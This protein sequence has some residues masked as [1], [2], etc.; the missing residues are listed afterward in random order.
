MIYP[1]NFL[2]LVAML[3]MVAGRAF[4]DRA[5]DYYN[6]GVNREDRSDWNGALA[7]YN[8][9]IEL[10]PNYAFAYNNRGVVKRT[11]GDLDGALADENK[12][13]GLDPNIAEA[14][15]NRGFLKRLT[16]DLDG[17][18]ADETKAIELKP[19]F[20]QAWYNR[21]LVKHAGANWVAHWLISRKP[22]DSRPILRKPGMVVV[23]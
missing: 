7:D 1:K 3:V 15:Y 16:G 10:N 17:A 12:A 4:G 13:I 20:A 23:R 14:W 19:D 8:K 22:S 18:L 2:L 6:S 11:N 9:A 21:G 5:F